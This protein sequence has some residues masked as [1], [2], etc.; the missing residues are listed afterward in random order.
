M[1]ELQGQKFIECAGKGV[2]EGSDQMVSEEQGGFRKG[3]GYTD[4]I[5]VISLTVTEVSWEG[6]DVVCCIHG[7]RK[8]I[9]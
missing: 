1:Q 9:K 2:W 8:F 4:Q 7:S 5:F 3:E 6:E